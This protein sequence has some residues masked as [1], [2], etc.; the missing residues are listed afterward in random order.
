MLRLILTLSLPLAL[1]ACDKGGGDSGTPA[2]D[3]GAADDTGV[4]GDDGSG[5][6]GGSDDGTGDDGTGDDGAGDD[7]TGGDDTGVSHTGDTDGEPE[8]TTSWYADIS[9]LLQTH[10][11]RCHYE[12]GLGTGDF[13][14]Y[15]TASAF[16]EI[17]LAA[18][19]AQ[20][21]PPATSDPECRDYVG[22]EHLNLPDEG[23][24]LLAT[25]LKEGTP[26][27]DPADAVTVELISE[28]LQ[29][30]NLELRIAE[31][32]T[33]TFSDSA[34]P[35]NEYRCFVLDHGQTEDFYLNT[36]APIVT[37]HAMTHHAVLYS[38][39]SSIPDSL[40][41]PEGFSCINGEEYRYI[42]E[43]LAG[44][45]PGSLPVEL[46]EG[47]GI[48]VDADEKFILQMH[49]F[50]PGTLEEGTSDQPG[51]AFQIE[52][53]VEKEAWVETLG[54]YGFNIPAGDDHYTASGS[55]TVPFAYDLTLYSVFPHMHVLGSG[56]TMSLTHEDGTE[57]CI[58]SADAY[59]FENQLQYRFSEPLAL[60]GGSRLNYECVW[61]NS[62]SNP[63]L[64]NNPPE[65]TRYGER[66]D[67]EM[68]F[69]FSLMSL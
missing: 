60:P 36:M 55:S 39:S 1:I 10:C 27:G 13:Y 21:M 44:W 64:I 43:F 32:Y 29:D 22:S 68:C 49:Y 2:G 50:D 26:E 11:T 12:G 20:E 4:T 34:N 17:M 8:T 66:T 33:P 52:T 51:Y 58:L 47:V 40:S 56:Y 59:D 38:A 15:E 63:D 24:A 53:E 41:G 5:D 62:T 46:P 25:W 54:I 18:I 42:R 67:E 23:R 61:N 19:D 31:P 30:P 16:A 35:G 57:E 7:G 37:E 45:A 14:D 65:D 9:P 28:E 3:D 69:F 6:D 48:K